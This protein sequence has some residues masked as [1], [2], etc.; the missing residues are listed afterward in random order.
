MLRGVVKQHPERAGVI[1][2]HVD[3]VL[4][5]GACPSDYPIAKGKQAMS[6]EALRSQIHLRVRTNTIAAVT[7]VRNSAQHAGRG[8]TPFLPGTGV[9]LCANAGCDGKR[10]R[11]CR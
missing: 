1:E 8:H 7:R 3:E 9:S 6:L 5:I 4:H 2:V 11:G 10:L